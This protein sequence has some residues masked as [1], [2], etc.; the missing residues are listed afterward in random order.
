[1]SDE[2]VPSTS[3]PPQFGGRFLTDDSRVYDANAWDN[4]EWDE[5]QVDGDTLANAHML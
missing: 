3:R 2:A 1:M 5:E 4:V